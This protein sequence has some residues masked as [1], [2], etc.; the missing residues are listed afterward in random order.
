[1]ARPGASDLDER[2]SRAGSTD[3]DV[4]K[5]RQDFASDAVKARVQKDRDEGQALGLQATPTVYI[6]GREYTDPKDT[7]S[8]R[9]WIKEELGR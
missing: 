9:A 4:A 1:M 5:L 8:F 2:L 3:V 7:E 6:N